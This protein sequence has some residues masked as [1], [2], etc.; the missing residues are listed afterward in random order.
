ADLKKDAEKLLSDATSAVSFDDEVKKVGDEIKQAVE[1]PVKTET[2]S[3][4]TAALETDKPKSEQ[5]RGA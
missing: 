4:E 5:D 3:D 2:S 1:E